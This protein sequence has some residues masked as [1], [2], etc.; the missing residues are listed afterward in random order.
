MSDAGLLPDGGGASAD[1]ASAAPGSGDGAVRAAL[2][3]VRA[4]S[5]RM[6]ALLE[7]ENGALR[8][9]D[10]AAAA[11]LLGRKMQAAD[12]LVAAHARLAQAAGEAD[13]ARLAGNGDAGAVLSVA[14]RL[15]QLL[16][17]NSD[18]L[19]RALE[20]QNRVIEAI[21]GAVP[22][23]LA[24]RAPSYGATGS[25]RLPRRMD[26]FAFSAKA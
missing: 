13:A 6:A 19:A 16:A 12:A 24:A 9:R 15:R 21:V 1:P 26:A 18:L 3:E 17:E 11:G 25:P 5:E 4:W 20:L 10:F 8:E 23:A 2:A 7:Q 22:K 14:G